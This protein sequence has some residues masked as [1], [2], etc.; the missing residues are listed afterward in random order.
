MK[1]I[2]SLMLATLFLIAS[3]NFVQ[4]AEKKADKVKFNTGKLKKIELVESPVQDEMTVLIKED[5]HD[6]TIFGDATATKAQMVNYI[7]KHNPKAKLNCSIEEI[8]DIYYDAPTSHFVKRL[9]KQVSGITAATL[10]RNKIII[11]GSAQQETKNPA[12]V[13]QLLK[14][15]RVH[16]F[17]ICLLTLQPIRRKPRL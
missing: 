9:K 13:L 6:V 3:V 5:I 17:N 7:R 16:T 8:V 2:F 14:S 10:I 1:K 11:V 4:A 12:Q 15:E